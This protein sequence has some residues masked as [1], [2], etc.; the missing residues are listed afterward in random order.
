MRIS[1]FLAKLEVLPLQ[2]KQRNFNADEYLFATRWDQ[3]VVQV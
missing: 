3:Q 1:E 2:F